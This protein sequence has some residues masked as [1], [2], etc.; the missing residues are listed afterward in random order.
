VDFSHILYLSSNSPMRIEASRAAFSPLAI[1][2][3]RGWTLNLALSS[4]VEF[5]KFRNAE[6]RRAQR[7]CLCELCAL[8]VSIPFNFAVLKTPPRDQAVDH[9]PGSHEIGKLFFSRY[10]KLGLGNSWTLHTHRTSRQCH[11]MD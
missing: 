2:V 1:R 11:P 10:L 6:S 4:Q 3:I 8:C 7:D 5:K 9:R